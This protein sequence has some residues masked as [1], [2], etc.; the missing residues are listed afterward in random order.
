MSTRT[1][2]RAWKIVVHHVH[3]TPQAENLGI[4][5]MKKRPLSWYAGSIEP[6]KEDQG[7]G[8]HLHLFLYYKNPQEKHVL[9]KELQTLACN[10]QLAAPRPEGEVRDWN[11]VDIKDMKVKDLKKAY[12]GC[13]GYLLGDTKDKPTGQIFEGKARPCHRR[14]RYVNK[15]YEQFCSICKQC[16]C[17]GCCEGCD[18]CTPQSCPQDELARRQSI[19]HTDKEIER[20]LKQNRKK[21]ITHDPNDP[22]AYPRIDYI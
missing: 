12:E 14:V 8:H 22:F 5:W 1:R 2:P 6:N 13:I 19:I 3:C 4:T 18:I 21:V 16:E 11:R 20:C 9:L 7:P 15:K 17:M 10:P